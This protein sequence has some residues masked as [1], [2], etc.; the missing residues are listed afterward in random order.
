MRN[1]L[2]VT[3]RN[4]VNYPFEEVK[5]RAMSKYTT[6]EIAKLCGVS[7]R[8]VQYYDA[9]D[10]LVPTELSEGGRRIYSEKDLRRMKIICILRELDLPI[11]TIGELLSEK[12]ADDVITNLLNEQDKILRTEIAEKQSRLD[13]LED[14]KKHLKKSKSFSFES[15]GDVAYMIEYKKKLCKVRAVMI[16]VGIVMNIIEVAMLILW[17][18]R[19]FW[20][21][22]VIGIGVVVLMSVWVCKFYY[23]R[24]SYICPQCH[25][26]F[27]PVLKQFLWAKHTSSTRKITCT[28]C[29]HHGFCM[30]TYGK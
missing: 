27:K 30:E 4:T 29:G 1:L 26:V 25:R 22:F 20:W 23:K 6:G 24:I 12:D 28:A 8:T 19:G 7:V 10:I 15:I 11:K 3:L 14:I 16:C 17:I 9:R 2:L 5:Q 13:K 21:P 18:Q